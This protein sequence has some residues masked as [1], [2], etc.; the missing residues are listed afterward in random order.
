[1]KNK[2]TPIKILA[3]AAF[4]SVAGCNTSAKKVENAEKNVSEAKQDLAKA[5]SEYQA[6]VEAYRVEVK[7]KIRENN[8]R[9]SEITALTNYEKKESTAEYK[10]QIAELE[11]KNKD[12][13][14]R[15]DEYKADASD[16]WQQFKSEFSRDMDELGLALKNFVTKN[17]SE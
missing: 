6:D 14:K 7:N 5:N 9:I 10:A 8:Q 11:R 3:I 12:M 2:I 1:M 13:A 15:M 4:L 16:G 17:K